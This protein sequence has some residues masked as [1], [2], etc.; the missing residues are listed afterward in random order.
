MVQRLRKSPANASEAEAEAEANVEGS[1]E[2]EEMTVN[3]I[4]HRRLLT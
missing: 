1:E 2:G 4:G 3:Q